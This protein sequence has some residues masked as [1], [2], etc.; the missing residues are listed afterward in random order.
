MRKEGANQL[1]QMQVL[2][3]LEINVNIWI[4]AMCVCATIR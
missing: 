1:F 4:Y 3:H 2:F